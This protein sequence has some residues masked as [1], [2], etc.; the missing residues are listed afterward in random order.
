MDFKEEKGTHRIF[1]YLNDYWVLTVVSLAE[2]GP[3]QAAQPRRFD[4]VCPAIY[5]RAGYESGADSV[6]EAE[7]LSFAEFKGELARRLREGQ[8]VRDL[9]RWFE[10]E[11]GRGCDESEIA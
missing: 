2:H 9:I 11:N 8:G 5:T 7:F 4:K 10:A 6:V 3:E 1:A